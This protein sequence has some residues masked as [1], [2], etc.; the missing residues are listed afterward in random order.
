MDELLIGYAVVNLLLILPAGGIVVTAVMASVRGRQRRARIAVGHEDGQLVFATAPEPRIPDEGPVDEVD[1]RPRSDPE[2]GPDPEPTTDPES[3]R[4][5]R[6]EWLTRF[7]D[8]VGRRWTTWTGVAAL[9]AGAAF[10]VMYAIEHGWFGPTARVVMGATLGAVLIAAG[11]RFIQRSMSALGKGLVGGGLAMIYLSIFAACALYS[12]LPASIAF[13]LMAIVAAGGIFLSIRHDALPI[14]IISTAC[15][16]LVPIILDSGLDKRDAVFAYLMVLDAAVL[17]VAL[18][19]RWRALDITAFAGTWAVFAVWFFERYSPAQMWPGAG[20]LAGFFAIFLLIPFADHWRRRTEVTI[21]RFIMTVLNATAV[22]A[23]AVG[24]MGDLDADALGL[25]TLGMAGAYLALA[26]LTGRRIPFDRKSIFAFTALSISL[27]TI[28]TPILL[29]MNAVAVAW[30][31]EAVLIAW[32]AYRYDY[33]PAR[34]GAFIAM[35]LAVGKVLFT[36]AYPHG[37]GLAPFWAG[38]PH[39]FLNENLFTGLFVTAAAFAFAW[40]GKANAAI[41]RTPDRVFDR[42]CGLGGAYLGMFVASRELWI[43]GDLTGGSFEATAVFPAIWATGF[44]L[45]AFAGEKMKSRSVRTGAFAA[46]CAAAIMI[47]VAF[48]QTHPEPYKLVFNVRFAAAL[49]AVLAALG[50]SRLASNRVVTG[51][52]YGVFAAGLLVLFSAESYLFFAETI[53]DPTKAQWT[54]QMSLSIV[55]A[56]YAAGALAIGFATRARP[57]RLAALGLFGATAI[58]LSLVDLADLRD[59]YR[60]ISFIVLGVLM[61]G[62]SYLYHRAEKRLKEGESADAA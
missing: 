15:G 42:I 21:E 5:S 19:K 13:G 46:L 36:D 11:E 53:A 62:A 22:F 44:A 23:L 24:M 20:W 52:M 35:C 45:L 41:A 61:I 32:L 59:G 40:I 29:D 18:F 38:E 25:F 47:L 26:F 56:L 31:V 8:V 55:W 34:V 12:L 28:A 10:F 27:A 33:F 6:R 39:S 50:Y 57:L 48:G 1:T 9:F 37:A 49:S 7:E 14:S 60:I 16:F 4:R 54:A 3:R 17:A 43:W 2:P 51:W 58:K 30:A